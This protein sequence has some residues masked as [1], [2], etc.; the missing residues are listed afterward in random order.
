MTIFQNLEIKLNKLILIKIIL[1]L[2][3]YMIETLFL[4]VLTDMYDFQAS[5]IIMA[6]G[7]FHD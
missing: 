5:S 6:N 7:I 4:I 3:N 1:I 2:K